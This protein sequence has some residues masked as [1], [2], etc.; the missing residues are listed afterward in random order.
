MID[1]T[2]SRDTLTRALSKATD[3]KTRA[4]ILLRRATLIP[5]DAD[6]RQALALDPDNPEVYRQLG[7]SYMKDRQYDRAVE[8]YGQW[9]DRLADTSEWK[10]FAC[11]QL[12]EAHQ[13][14]GDYAKAI[15]AYEEAQRCP[16]DIMTFPGVNL[17]HLAECYEALGEFDKFIR[18]YEGI[19]NPI[20]LARAYR[21]AG[22][23]EQAREQLRRSYAQPSPGGAS[24]EGYRFELAMIEACDGNSEKA[25]R[26]LIADLIRQPRP[27]RRSL[28]DKVEQELKSN[29]AVAP[30]IRHTQAGFQRIEV[31]LDKGV[32]F[33]NQQAFAKA[34]RAF[35][36]AAQ[37]FAGGCPASVLD[38]CARTSPK[39]WLQDYFEQLIEAQTWAG[40]DPWTVLGLMLAKTEAHQSIANGLSGIGDLRIVD[41]F[42]LLVALKEDS[43]YQAE[44]L[45]Q[46]IWAA[47]ESKGFSSIAEAI[48]DESRLTLMLRQD[49]F[50]ENHSPQTSTHWRDMLWAFMQGE[51]WSRAP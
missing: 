4:A 50:W 32:R 11:E 25:T 21:K 47:A 3:D 36:Q 2:L 1:L 7:E 35:E 30:W 6:Y 31:A 42:G 14:R 12:G 23:I 43:A 45:L 15:S 48:Q 16:I 10:G 20:A 18:V 19:G 39:R 46:C 5:G 49:A 33:S 28:I 29:A 17:D 44:P 40:G 41:D 8:V 38:W 51:A 22:K 27:D 37:E 34:F 26:D 13:A 9:K 24:E